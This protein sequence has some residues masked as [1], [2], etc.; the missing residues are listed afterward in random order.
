MIKG[1]ITPTV[2]KATRT[3]K[4]G[5]AMFFIKEIHELLIC[6]HRKN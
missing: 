4:T 2:S 6:L 1:V 3:E 5:K